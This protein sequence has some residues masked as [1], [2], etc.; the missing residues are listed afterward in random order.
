MAVYLDL[1]MG[2]NFGVDFLLLLGS[3]RLSGFPPG[4]GRTAAA[5]ALG[6][7]YAG[8]CLLPGFHF[9]GNTLWRL[10]FLGLMGVI[11]FGFHVSAWK[12]TGIFV[13]LSMALGGIAVGLD[14]GTLGQLL[15]GALGVWLLCRVGF[16]RRVGG[17][18]FVPITVI[19]G[20][21]SA[22]VVALKDTGNS[23]RDPVTGEQVLIFGPEAAGKLLQLTREQLLSPLQ[24]LTENPGAG[25]R[26][27]PCSAVGNSGSMLLAKRFSSVRIGDRPT[28][29][30]VAFAPERIG[31][32]DVYQ[33]LAGGNTI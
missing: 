13:L 29:A 19:H 11:A 6:A 22:S 23:L 31:V 26:L 1:V 33:A 20:D 18:E 15:L 8:A 27:I 24:T 17:R 14:R 25:L 32:G 28:N 16:G 5:A 3:N 7:V 30:L 10:V 4:Y 2:L 12:R 9:L 21:R